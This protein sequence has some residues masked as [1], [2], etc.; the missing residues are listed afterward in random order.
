MG[1]I[2]SMAV[3]TAMQRFISFIYF[4]LFGKPLKKTAPP[5]Y[6]SETGYWI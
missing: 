4:L 6:T 3:N 5:S 1:V 2:I